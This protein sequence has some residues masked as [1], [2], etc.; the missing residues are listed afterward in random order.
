MYQSLKSV[1]VIS[2]DLYPLSDIVKGALQISDACN[3]LK[4]LL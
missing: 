2:I 3:L 1:A 4:R